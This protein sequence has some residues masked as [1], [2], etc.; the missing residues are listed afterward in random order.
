MRKLLYF[1]IAM[2][3]FTVA[4]SCRVEYGCPPVEYDESKK[5]NVENAEHTGSNNS[6]DRV[7]PNSADENIY[8]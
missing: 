5:E 1:L 7:E 3:G 2:L 4:T 8:E 6:T